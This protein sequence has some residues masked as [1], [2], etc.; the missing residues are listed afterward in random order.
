MN[1]EKIKYSFAPSFI[2]FVLAGILIASIIFIRDFVEEES[3]FKSLRFVLSRNLFLTMLFLFAGM[4]V[5]MY[6]NFQTYESIFNTTN[7]NLVKIFLNS[8]DIQLAQ[9]SFV[10]QTAFGI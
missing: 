9:S 10:N 5:A 1:E 4:L 3:L 7:S 6:S 8:S 2:L